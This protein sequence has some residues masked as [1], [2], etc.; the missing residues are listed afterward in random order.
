MSTKKPGEVSGWYSKPKLSEAERAEKIR[1]VDEW[2]RKRI[3]LNYRQIVLEVPGKML[4]ALG[5]MAQDKGIPF[6]EFVESII[7]EYLERSGIDWRK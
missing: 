4:L 7:T 3:D 6:G 2:Y 1:Q 5:Q